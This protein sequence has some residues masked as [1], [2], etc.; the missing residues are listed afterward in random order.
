MVTTYDS[1]LLGVKAWLRDRVVMTVAS[2]GQVFSDDDEP[3]MDS[4]ANLGK[5]EEHFGATAWIA[6]A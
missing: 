6:S 1:H 4:V 5:L 2:I 3:L